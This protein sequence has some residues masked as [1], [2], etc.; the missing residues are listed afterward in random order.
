MKSKIIPARTSEAENLY[1]RAA[2]AE[3]AKDLDTAFR[4]YIQAGSAFLSLSR[5]AS[6]LRSR[7]R[8]ERTRIA[9]W[10]AQSELRLESGELLELSPEQKEAGVFW[11]RP[12]EVFANAKI[13]SSDLRPEDIVQRVVADCSLCA[14]IIIC[15]LHSR[16]HD[17]EVCLSAL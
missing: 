11:R 1:A 9:H 8:P 7:S 12:S 14:S 4:L 13:F 10:I 15:L 5:A 2:K 17:S 16:T 3:L 6:H